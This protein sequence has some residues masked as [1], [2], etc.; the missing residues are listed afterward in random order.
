[1]ADTSWYFTVRSDE[2]GLESYGPYE[3]QAAA[4]KGLERIQAKAVQADD[5]VHREYALPEPIAPDEYA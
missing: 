1:M 2:Y 4:I 3:S 5:G